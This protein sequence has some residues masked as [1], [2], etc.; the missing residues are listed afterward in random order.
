MF[1][2]Q[3]AQ[4]HNSL[5]DIPWDLDRDNIFQHIDIFISRCH[6]M[7]EICQAMIDFAR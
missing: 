4:A 6:D 5:T 2:L 7:I 1:V 3:I